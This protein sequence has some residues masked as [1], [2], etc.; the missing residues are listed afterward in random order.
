MAT[1]YKAMPHSYCR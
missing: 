1:V